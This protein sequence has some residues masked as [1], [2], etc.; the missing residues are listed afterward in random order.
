MARQDRQALNEDGPGPARAGST[1]AP[2]VVVAYGSTFGTTEEIAARVADALEARLGR[3]PALC[4]VAW[5]DAEAIARHEV[6]ILGAS[7]WDDGQLQADWAAILGDLAAHDLRGRR[8][9]VFGCGDGAGYP[10]TFGDALAILRDRL[11]DVGAQAIGAIPLA[12]LGLDP[13]GF[14]ASR[15]REGESLVGLLLDDAWDDACRHAA[16]DAWCDRLARAMAG[17]TPEGSPAGAGEADAE[18]TFTVLGVRSLDG[19]LG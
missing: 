7:T 10:D 5:T 9:A 11:H 13:A 12:D 6:L 4:D 19:R 2:S 18:S 14:P 8:V 17:S 15:A 3:R 1:D 16:V